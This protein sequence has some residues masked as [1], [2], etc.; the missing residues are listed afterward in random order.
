MLELRLLSSSTIVMLLTYSSL[1]S[2]F[3]THMLY[4]FVVDTA[5]TYLVVLSRYWG[6]LVDPS[7]ILLSVLIQGCIALSQYYKFDTHTFSSLSDLP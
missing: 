3:L 2:S 4:C 5:L 7:L 1:L 6:H